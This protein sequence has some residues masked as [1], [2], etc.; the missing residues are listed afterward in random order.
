MQNNKS[1]LDWK[2]Q[3]QQKRRKIKSVTINNKRSKNRT[4]HFMSYTW[5]APWK[6]VIFLCVW[7]CWLSLNCEIRY[8]LHGFAIY[9]VYLFIHNFPW[10]WFRICPILHAWHKIDCK[11]TL[12]F[13]I[14]RFCVFVV[15]FFTSF[16]KAY[17]AKHT[18]TKTAVQKDDD[19]FASIFH[20]NRKIL[21]FDMFTFQK[22]L[23]SVKIR[24]SEHHVQIIQ[25][26]SIF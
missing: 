6:Y 14:I 18:C 23:I 24:T 10:I 20:P 4:S 17:T 22:R 12:S 5:I 8:V 21:A 1:I 7:Y 15:R 25:M 3:Q 2:L 11:K 16:A 19:E 13:V 9:I 26:L